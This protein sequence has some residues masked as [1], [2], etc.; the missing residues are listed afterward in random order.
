M[1]DFFHS[2]SGFVCGRK[3]E[4]NVKLRLRGLL[5]RVCLHWCGIVSI[6]STE[7]EG[8]ALTHMEVEG[9]RFPEKAAAMDNGADKT[10]VT[11]Q[12]QSCW[13]TCW[14]SLLSVS[15]AY[16]CV[17]G[18]KVSTDRIVRHVVAAFV[19]VNARFTSDLR[20]P[21]ES[22]VADS[23]PSRIPVAIQ[24]QI[25]FLLGRARASSFSNT[26]FKVKWQCLSGLRARPNRNEICN[27]R[28]IGNVCRARVPP[29]NLQLEFAAGLQ[30]EC[31]WESYLFASGNSRG[32]CKSDVSRAWLQG[33]SEEGVGTLTAT[34]QRLQHDA[35]FGLSIP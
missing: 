30:L 28:L 22:P 17:T 1:Q 35:R 20:L 2:G 21:R 19:E 31:D 26:S 32:R 23:F 14:E 9:R 34:I 16:V 27:S 3:Q 24:L 7:F 5:G 25:L 29:R 12:Q 8:L 11:R 15:H 10:K 33:S 13:R 18:V 4:V 6:N